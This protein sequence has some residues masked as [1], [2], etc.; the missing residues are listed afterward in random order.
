MRDIFDVLLAFFVSSAKV[1]SFFL[2]LKTLK[3][4]LVN[5]IEL[6]KEISLLAFG[7]AV[8][9]KFRFKGVKK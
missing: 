7:N 5:Q 6:G 1:V 9:T 8:G 4:L 3:V 2:Y